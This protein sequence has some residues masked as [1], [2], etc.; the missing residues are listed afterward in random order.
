MI[1]PQEK[2]TITKLLDKYGPERVLKALERGPTPNNWSGC[3]LACIYGEKG[4]LNKI[5]MKPVP[6]LDADTK[7]A[8]ALDITLS[9]LANIVGIFDTDT[10]AFTTLV[11]RVA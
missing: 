4:E 3:F 5:G 11:E 7:M 8:N 10:Q 1:S 6:L 9:E 2:Q